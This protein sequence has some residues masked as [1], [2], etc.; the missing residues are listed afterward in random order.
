VNTDGATQS[1]LERPILAF[2][3]MG[4][5]K[6]CQEIIRHVHHNA[7]LG[8]DALAPMEKRNGEPQ[9]HA[10]VRNSVEDG[11][12]G[13]LNDRGYVA[14]VNRDA[15]TITLDGAERLADL[16]RIQDHIILLLGD[17]SFD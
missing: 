10:I 2:L 5:S 9:F 4:H 3:K 16:V 6:T 8:P 14:S 13:N 11:R 15:Y 17:K 7:N 1:S 12:K